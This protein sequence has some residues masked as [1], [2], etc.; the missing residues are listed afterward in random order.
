MSPGGTFPILSVTRSPSGRTFE[1]QRL[2]R[3]GE[4]LLRS[5][6]DRISA[7]LGESRIDGI[8]RIDA[9]RAGRHLEQTG[10]RNELG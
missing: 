7:T 6:E 2:S 1:A 8:E 5:G 3:R 4:R 9:L 10:G